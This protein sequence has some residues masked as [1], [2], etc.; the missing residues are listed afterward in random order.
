MDPGITS[1]KSI[2]PRSESRVPEQLLGNLNL[3]PRESK[4]FH[5]G[6]EI[7]MFTENSYYLCV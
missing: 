2:M 1:I 3:S 5:I 7:F 4:Q 6:K